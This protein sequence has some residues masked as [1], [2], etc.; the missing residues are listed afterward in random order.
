MDDE[1]V[2]QWAVIL[3]AYLLMRRVS[4]M[5]IGR[6]TV[7]LNAFRG[8][9]LTY[10][11]RCSS[12]RM[13]RFTRFNGEQF[14][15][16]VKTLVDDY[17]LR[18][19]RQ[20]SAAQKVCLFLHGNAEGYSYRALSEAFQHSRSTVSACFHEV[21]AAAVLLHKDTVKAPERTASEVLRKR[22]DSTKYW[23]HFERCVGAIDGTHLAAYVQGRDPAAWRNR[24]GTL[25]QNVLAAVDFD[26]NFTYVLPGWEGSVH[27]RRVFKAA[28]ASKGFTAPAGC[29]Y[30]ADAGY[31]NTDITLVPYRGVRYHLRE[32][33]AVGLR[34][35]TPHELFNLRHSSL[36]N[37]VERTFGIFKK[38]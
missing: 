10:E 26:M 17:G 14:E 29:Y 3:A 8:E 6:R 34:P 15:A 38:R 21:L 30:L 28:R 7:N 23:P 19:G 5:P 9:Q 35:K 1:E 37:V 32:V 36:R 27:D 22:S 11:L 25:S 2:K 18:D 31:S 12:P 13:Q 16:V 24:K 20:I 33:K 4:N